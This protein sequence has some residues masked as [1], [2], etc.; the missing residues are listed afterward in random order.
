MTLNQQLQDLVGEVEA[1]NRAI[2]MA[3]EQIP[4]AELRGLSVDAF[5]ALPPEPNVDA[6]IEAAERALAAAREQAPVRTT[7][8]LQE[9]RIQAV[10]VGPVTESL[11][12]GLDDL[13]IAAAARVQAHLAEL[14]E[15]GEAWVADGV[16]RMQD[17]DQP[18][19]SCPFCA[20]DLGGSP[21]LHHY[22]AFFGDAYR[23]LKASVAESLAA[24]TRSFRQDFLLELERAVGGNA[25]R[26]QFW[27]RFCDVP[28]IELDTEDI[29]RHWAVVAEAVLAALRA[30][31]ASPLEAL[32][33]P[34]EVFDSIAVLQEKGRQVTAIN[35]EIV[36]AN[37]AIRAVK[38]AAAGADPAALHSELQRLLAAKA[39]HTPAIS[40][41]CDAYLAEKAAKLL[42]EQR[43]DQARTALTNYRTQ[44]FP[45][46]QTAINRYLQLFGAGFRLERIQAVN[47][48]GGS[49]CS[50]DVVINNT[51]VSIAG[52]A[53]APDS[54]GFHNTL[55]AGDRNT[56]ALAF[57]FASLDQCPRLNDKVVVI[58]DPVSSLDDHRCLTTTQE[59]RRLSRRAAQVI[60][61]SHSKPFL[62]TLWEGVPQAERADRAALELI[63]QGSGSV[64]REWDV[65]RECVSEHDRRH[66]LL[67]EYLEGNGGNGR[68]VAE[69]I[70]P[71]LESF[72]RVASPQYFIPGML[73]GP[74][75]GLCEQRVG[76]AQ[77][78]LD[79]HHLDEL[80]DLIEY[81]NRFHHDT[82]AAWQAEVVND[83]ELLGFVRRTLAFARR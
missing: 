15:G 34:R 65:T 69:A 47:N 55:S 58:D 38:A 75:R 3:A 6:A 5:C 71:L 13:D 48:R 22:R 39:R 9:L 43:R 36:A 68:V 42:T 78:I 50:Y 44:I 28:D 52:R 23:D 7:G 24:A 74:F 8:L 33:L 59:I 56:L 27:S 63:R 45:T 1:H 72:L 32:E 70:R 37:E 35:A 64:L 83:A 73:L 21:V 77:E 79:Q 80:R 29:G 26:K 31:Q 19:H 60:V 61:L 57:F 20:Q 18:G 81:S 62:C 49:A 54:H 10:D 2:R 14:G 40:L 30:K 76:G 46:Y 66:A 53:G 11:Q 51:A 25:E 17:D 67:R 16:H 82:N 4:A 41:L 12:R